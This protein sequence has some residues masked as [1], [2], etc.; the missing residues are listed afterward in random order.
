MNVRVKKLMYTAVGSLVGEMN[1]EDT[2]KRIIEGLYNRL[3]STN[4][5]PIRSLYMVRRLGIVDSKEES[6]NIFTRI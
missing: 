1:K 6:Q 5:N 2:K 4:N 3:D